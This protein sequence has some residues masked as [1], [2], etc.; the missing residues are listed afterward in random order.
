MY[1]RRVLHQIEGLEFDK[2]V[3]STTPFAMDRVSQVFTLYFS[4][5]YWCFGNDSGES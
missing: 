1:Y 3:M 5:I 2:F 4:L